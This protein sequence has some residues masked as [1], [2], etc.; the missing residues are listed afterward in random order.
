M[1]P[2]D[3]PD[4]LR[5]LPEADLPVD[6]LR[7]WMLQGPHGLAIFL[8]AE[9]EI[10]LPKHTHGHQWGIVVDGNMDLTIGGET[11][12]YRRGDSYFVPAGVAHHG[13]LYPGF[14][15]IDCFEDPNRYRPRARK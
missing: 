7:G 13:K 2:A 4:F 10:L 1:K 14:R 12:T 3:Y 11:K 15:A 8:H 9:T 6:G 5:K